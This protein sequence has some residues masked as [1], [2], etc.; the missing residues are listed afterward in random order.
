M[1]DLSHHYQSKR[2]DYN[3]ALGLDEHVPLGNIGFCNIGP[4]RRLVAVRQFN[5]RLR[6]WLLPG[7]K[8]GWIGRF[9]DNRAYYFIV[10]DSNFNFIR[11][12]ECDYKKLWALEDIRLMNI[13]GNIIQ[14]SATD[15]SPG[16]EKYGMC[17]IQFKMCGIDN[18]G[19]TRLDAVKTHA[20]PIR[21]EKNYMPIEGT[22][23]AFVTD[24][25][26]NKF[27]VQTIFDHG[28]KR[29]CYCA[30]LRPIRGSSPLLRYNGGYVAVVHRKI[31][32]QDR[33]INSFMFCNGKMTLCMF[34]REFV[35]D[36]AKS[37][38]NFLCGMSVE[39]GCAVLPFCVNDRLTYLFKIPLKD[40]DR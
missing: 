25:E 38:I 36:G 33:Y 18:D 28:G 13:G 1:L 9:L 4:N 20:F 32:R 12:V 27:K 37:P 35:V 16:Q 17:S 3:A 14:A 15:V 19:P 21:H 26:T 29:N 8:P 39:N 31:P 6:W 7:E 40:F 30:G 10:T 2:L 34:S 24:I 5:Y 11:R 23:G 22:V